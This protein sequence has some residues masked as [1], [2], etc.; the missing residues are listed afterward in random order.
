MQAKYSTITVAAIVNVNELKSALTAVIGVAKKYGES[1]F[2]IGDISISFC[3]I[4]NSDNKIEVSS[5]ID[6]KK[7]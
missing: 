1:V 4:S 3:A 2:E 7:G 6:I 5:Y